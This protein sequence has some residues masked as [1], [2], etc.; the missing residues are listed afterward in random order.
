[1]IVAG[2]L[3][4]VWLLSSRLGTSVAV[5]VV[6][7]LAPVLTVAWQ[8]RPARKPTPACLT[9]RRRARLRLHRLKGKR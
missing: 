6:A 3:V 5:L 1:M 4:A 7:V 2:G 8:L 9:W